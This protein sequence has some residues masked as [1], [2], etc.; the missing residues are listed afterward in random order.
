[1]GEFF[2]HVFNRG[3][4]QRK[5][6]L[7]AVDYHKFEKALFLCND[8]TRK[9][10]NAQSKYADELNVKNN[11]PYVNI[12]AYCLM[13][14]HFHLLVEELQ[15]MG[16][17]EF[18]GRV[19][20]S[21]TKFF[22]VRYERTGRLFEAPYKRKVVNTTNY[23]THLTRYIHLNPLDLILPGWKIDGIRNW[24][25]VES[26]LCGYPWSSYKNYVFGEEKR[27]LNIAMLADA[28]ASPDDYQKF[29]KEWA[30]RELPGFEN[31]LF[32]PTRGVGRYPHVGY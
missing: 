11:K 22:N 7:D 19:G 3:T 24:E 5:I 17:S 9:R 27:F 26:F 16:T 28:F 29:V 25:I 15:P 31:V 23:L 4:D 8:A 6:F 13:P 20:N 1:M 18:L 2:W 14:N 21:Y 12:L 10:K 30:T 32:L